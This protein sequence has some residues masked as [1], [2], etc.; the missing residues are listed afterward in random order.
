MCENIDLSQILLKN[1]ISNKFMHDEVRTI[2]L[3]LDIRTDGQIASV[4]FRKLKNSDLKMNALKRNLLD[5]VEDFCLIEDR[6]DSMINGPLLHHEI[7]T[8]RISAVRKR[9]GLKIM[10]R[11]VIP[12]HRPTSIH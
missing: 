11:K 8:R 3:F 5:L 7:I 9:L 6:S 1:G 4:I 10:T 2:I 12:Y